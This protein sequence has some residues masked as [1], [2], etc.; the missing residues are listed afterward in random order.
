[1][2]D[3]VL[4][5]GQ[6]NAVQVGE[7]IYT[8]RTTWAERVITLP[9]CRA[10]RDFYLAMFGITDHAPPLCIDGTDYAR[11]RRARRRIK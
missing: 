11:R 4:R 2:S 9:T 7:T 8:H 5:G 3:I 10:H 1:M 6:S